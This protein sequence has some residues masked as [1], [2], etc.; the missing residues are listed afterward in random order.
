MCSVSL[1]MIAL[2]EAECLP[3]ALANWRDVA[4][5]LIVVVDSRTT[6]ET[7]AIV[8]AAGGTALRYEYRYPG[9]KGAARM[10]GIEAAAGEWIVVLDADEAIREQAALRRILMEAEPRVTAL[11]L[12]FENYGED[13]RMT[14]RWYQ[15]RAFRRGLYR[16]VHREHEM[17][18]WC[19][20]GEPLEPL[21]DVVVEHRA[22][23]G[24]AAS[25]NGAMLDRLRLDAAE[26][27]EDAH[28]A[29]F[30]HRQLLIAGEFEAALEAGRRYLAFEGVEYCECYGNMATACLHL[31]DV[32]D[33]L[34]WLYRATAE[35]PARRIWWIR[36]AQTYM[37][38]GRW[39]LAMAHLRCAAEI[40]PGFA[41]QWEPAESQAGIGEMIEA[42]QANLA[43]VQHG[44]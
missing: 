6:D 28:S 35:E 3:R 15:V 34:G 40:W 29:Y 41:W 22:P 8:E 14:L 12:L 30:L 31:G 43:R 2:N 27:P 18:M 10:M 33:A 4:D 44:G 21:T 23:A 1:C 5:E 7:A 26:R 24:R 17:P 11:N 42:C 16:Y 37:A 32:Q 9:N 19:G 20:E 39:N 38:A 13:G 36:L 25:K